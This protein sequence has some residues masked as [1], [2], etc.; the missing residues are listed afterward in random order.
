MPDPK[1]PAASAEATPG[2]PPSPETSEV[3]VRL[4]AIVQQIRGLVACT[5]DKPDVAE[6]DA[7]EK[8]INQ[9]ARAK[10]TEFRDQWTALADAGRMQEAGDLLDQ[11][12]EYFRERE[13]HEDNDNNFLLKHAFNMFIRNEGIRF[14]QTIAARFTEHGDA[15]LPENKDLVSKAHEFGARHLRIRGSEMLKGGGADADA[16]KLL[17]ETA[18]ETLSPLVLQYEE[19]EEFGSACRAAYETAYTFVPLERWG[20]AALCFRISARMARQDPQET[21][22]LLIANN[23]HNWALKMGGTQ[24]VPELMDEYREFT[25]EVRRIAA[26]GNP[27]AK[28]WVSNALHEQGATALEIAQETRSANAD[29]NVDDWIAE[30]IECCD[31]VINDEDGYLAELD[32]Q[33][34]IIDKATALRRKAESFKD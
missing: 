3:V 30:V 16:G 8:T 33:R 14:L 32:E 7:A 27:T 22:G 31:A 29:A 20:E 24:P 9:I 18:R 5:T 6:P 10:F 15:D 2:T 34:I 13:L 11:L 17:I 21:L 12:F 19:R 26:E 4:E 25:R 23:E 1:R 28:R